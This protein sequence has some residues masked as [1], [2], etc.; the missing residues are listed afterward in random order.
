[1]VNKLFISNDRMLRLM[2]WAIGNGVARNQSDYL[3]QIGFFRTNLWKIKNGTQSFTVEHILNACTVTGASADYIFG[4]TNKMKRKD[5]VDPINMLK[6]AV[7]AL[8][9]EYKRKSSGTR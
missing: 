2:D 7:L 8:E 3:E 9:S 5:E 6:E 4:F 1:M